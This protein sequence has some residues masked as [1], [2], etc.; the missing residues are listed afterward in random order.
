MFCASVC[1]SFPQCVHEVAIDLNGDIIRSV[2]VISIPGE[3]TFNLKVHCHSRVVSN[4]SDFSIFDGREGI[5]YDGYSSNPKGN[6]AVHKGIMQ[7][8]LA[9]FVSVFVMHVMDGVHG[10]HIDPSQPIHDL[11]EGLHDSIVVQDIL[12][13]GFNPRDYGNAGDFIH[14]TIDGIE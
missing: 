11:L 9:G 4:R 14:S 1:W 3:R 2:V 6:V 8:H 10:L 5:G 13:D 7:S 12:K